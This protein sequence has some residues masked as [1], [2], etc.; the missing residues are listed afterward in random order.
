MGVYHGMGIIGYD[1]V[2]EKFVGNWID[3]HSTTIMQ[4]TGARAA[5]GSLTWTHSYTCPITRKPT[6]MKEIDRAKPD[7]SR[8]MEM[9][10]TDPVSGK[11]YKMMEFTFTRG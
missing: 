10:G 4:S 3:N 2:A 9:H 7:G 5:D 1:T 8:T 6:S 11:Y